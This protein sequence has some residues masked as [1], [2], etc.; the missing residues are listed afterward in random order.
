[1][2]H[3]YHFNRCGSRCA[4]AGEGSIVNPYD[5]MQDISLPNPSLTCRKI[6]DG[7]GIPEENERNGWMICN[8]G[9]HFCIK[10]VLPS[11]YCKA[12]AVVWENPY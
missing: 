5:G 12:V 10:V 3:L 8:R 2:L 9:H 4:D 11:M 7:Q 6:H 1:M